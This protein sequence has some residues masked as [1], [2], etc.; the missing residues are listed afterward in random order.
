MTDAAR[1]FIETYERERAALPGAGLAWLGVRRAEALKAFAEAGL[2]HRRLEDWRYTDLSR[3]L[4]NA[5]LSLAPLPDGAVVL[6]DATKRPSVAA[7]H[8]ID[9]HVIVFVNGRLRSDLSGVKLPAGVTLVS[10]GDALNATWARPLVE[11]KVEAQAGSVIALN[12][13]LMR[14][15]I[16]LHIARDAKLDKPL[17]LL[18][19][20]NDDGASHVRN[21]VRLEE[22]AEATIFET[23]V[24]AGARN[25]FADHV[26]DVSLG[27][28]ATLTH[29][30]IQ[31]EAAD[32][33]HL[34]SLTAELAASSKLSSFSLTLG[35]KLSRNQSFVTFKGEGGE[36]HVNGATALSGTQHGDHFCIVDHAVPNCSSATL[37]KTV[38]D[39]ASTGV[40]QGKVIVRPD[41]QK[42]DGRQMTN[43]LLLSRDAAMNAKP[44]LEIYADDVQCAHGSTIGELNREAIF[45]L[46]SRGIDEP[47]AR[48]LLISAFLDDAFET[49]PHEAARDDLRRLAASWFERRQEKTV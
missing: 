5:T 44:E 32:A 8:D 46:R 28:G 48:Q 24:D 41:A 15:G 13:A 30:K 45:Y 1:N 16:G 26:T 11:T 40:F 12:T 33:V 36:A 2:P 6:P 34:A 39:G 49:V 25:Y 7:F 4:G 19:L 20:A 43:A 27:K 35:A 17:H 37:F 47:T 21:L 38:L 22:G 18:F 10:L 23:H 3:A 29:V 31:D 9:R 42:T 14:D